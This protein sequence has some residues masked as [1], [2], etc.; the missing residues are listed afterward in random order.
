MEDIIHLGQQYNADRVWLSKIQD[1]NTF[2]NFE[3]QNIFNS[4]HPLH[5]DYQIKL[6]SL[7]E[8]NKNL[9]DVLVE[10]PTLT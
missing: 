1:W 8:Y 5:S 10:F 6:A 2:N 7:K 9:S 4:T 3:E